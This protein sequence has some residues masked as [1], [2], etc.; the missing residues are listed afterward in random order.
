MRRFQH[1]WQTVEV[2][3]Y[4]PALL[5]AIQREC[6]GIPIDLLIPR[7][8]SWMGLDV[9]AYLALH[10]ARLASARAVHLHPTQLSTA[11]V[12]ALCHHGI[13]IHLWDANDAQSWAKAVEY[14]IPRVCTDRF[15]QAIAFR[16][17]IYKAN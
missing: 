4:E 3:S 15:Q 8:E 12:A 6:P 1:L 17:N 14:R 16:D 5:V 11:G 10:R 7:S 13:E 2:T 9:V